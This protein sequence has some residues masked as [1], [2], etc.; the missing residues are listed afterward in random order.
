[1]GR[2][3]VRIAVVGAGRMGSVHLEAL[4]RAARA[5]AVAVVDPEPAARARA[6]DRGLRSHASVEELLAAGGFDAALIATPS[7]L[8]AELVER[9]ASAGIS[10]LCEKPC[11]LRA[12]DALAAGRA[13]ERAGIRLQVGYWR[14]FVPELEQL[15]SRLASGELGVP[16]LLS[17]HQWDEWP[18]S[19]EYRA[20][21]GG[22]AID[23]GVHELDQ[24]RWLLGQEI[25]ALAARPAG[26]PTADPGD[27]D[28]AV[29]VARLS[30]GAG[31]V[32]TLGRRFEPGDCCWLELTCERAYE[33]CPFMWGADAERAFLTALAAQ[34]DAF[35]DSLDDGA[36]RGAGAADAVAALAAAEWFDQALAR[37][38]TKPEEAPAR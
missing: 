25:E 27:P 35:A 36:A 12:G 38:E 33:R 17:C 2:A 11:G 26:P 32:I 20:T 8:H 6:A 31:L 15:R 1:M 5:R 14:R 21:S 13:A 34:A 22:I 30:G 23:M 19:P 24:A 3:Q 4:A 7:G 9:F 29:A 28:A 37:M 18:P 10:V 16:L